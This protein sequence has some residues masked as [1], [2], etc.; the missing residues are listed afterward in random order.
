[1]KYTLVQDEW[2]L[3]PSPDVLL[4]TGKNIL[5]VLSERG[6]YD[7]NNIIVGCDLRGPNLYNISNANKFKVDIKNILVLL[8]GLD[9]MPD[10]L[11]LV[12]ESLP[13]DIYQLK[14]RCHP[15]FP[16]EKPEFNKIRNHELYP[17]LTVTR[18]TTLEDDLKEADLVVYKGSTS[19]LY[20]AYKGIPLLRYQD[21]WWASDDPLIGCSSLKKIFSNSEELLNGIEEFQLMKEEV[22]SEEQKKMQAYVFDYMNPYKD[23][24]LNLLAS[25]LIS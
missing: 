24:E 8:E 18:G 21:E 14:V 11:L 25:K 9:T 12:M 3:K 4:V 7:F 16:I 17:K 19:A 22:F 20:A 6:G 5:N 1:M 23:S 15:V 13:L 10:L 2:R